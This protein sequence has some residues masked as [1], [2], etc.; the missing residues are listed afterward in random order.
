M[1][2]SLIESTIAETSCVR[3]VTDGVTT[4]VDIWVAVR[5]SAEPANLIDVRNAIL[6]VCSLVCIGDVL[7][8]KVQ[9]TRGASVLCGGCD[10][11]AVGVRDIGID[12]PGCGESKAFVV[13][14]RP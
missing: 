8:V 6:E 12:I 13:R 5:S 2:E 7:G 1:E 4:K 14:N 11:L 3:R 9:I 10:T